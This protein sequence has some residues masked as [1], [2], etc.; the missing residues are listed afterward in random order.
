M[1]RTN[2]STASFPDPGILYRTHDGSVIALQ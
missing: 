1:T 2:S